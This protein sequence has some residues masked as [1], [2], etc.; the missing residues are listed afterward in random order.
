MRDPLAGLTYGE[1]AGEESAPF[2]ETAADSLTMDY[3][4]DQPRDEN[5]RFTS[6][7]SSG[8]IKKTK[9]APSPQRNSS[10]VQL[11]PKAYAKLTGLMNTRFPGLEEGE[12]RRVFDS[13]N[14]YWIKADGYGGF[15]V[16]SKKSIKGK[17]RK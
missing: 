8:K 6:G 11:K 1:E 12:I 5:G 14:A 7:G 15:Q 4:P 2:E 9:Y 16:L 10:P 17:K 3:A 13:Q